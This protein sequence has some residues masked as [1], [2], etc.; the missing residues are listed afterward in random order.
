V[1]I[2][3][4]GT[5][6]VCTRP[7]DSRRFNLKFMY[8]RLFEKPLDALTEED[9][10][11]LVER[12][13]EEGPHLDFKLKLPGNKEE[14]KEL[15]RDVAAFANAY[16][17]YLIFGV[18]EEGG[19]AREL[20]GLEGNPDQNASGVE[21]T[22]RDRTEPPVEVH[23]VAV[24]LENG[25]H[26]LVVEVPRS[27]NAPHMADGRFYRRSGRST[28]PMHYLD[29]RRAF[30]EQGD[31][32]RKLR[33][34]FLRRIEDLERGYGPVE[35]EEAPALYLYVASIPAFDAGP[36]R[37]FG[38][39]DRDRV[40]SFTLMTT[41]DGYR[42]EFSADGLLAS[43]GK[44]SCREFALLTPEGELFLGA[45]PLPTCGLAHRSGPPYVLV[46]D[47]QSVMIQTL[48]TNLP[49]LRALGFEAP[50]YVALALVRAQGY[51]LRDEDPHRFSSERILH[52]PF[53]LFDQVLLDEDA[54]VVG[55]RIGRHQTWEV[56]QRIWRERAARLKPILDRLYQ[57]AGAS[58]SPIAHALDG[59]A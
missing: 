33:G 12:G 41:P 9:L 59:Q 29:V 49:D 35:W 46:H 7:H 45:G 18:Q 15:A 28:A 37:I 52:R 27:L 21:N 48:G 57:A 11:G 56:N 53:L 26:V 44:E 54:R 42:P 38:P 8:R 34:Q 19:D 30:A 16:G 32:I 39:E 58:Q 5:F 22:I 17:G 36:V 6:E 2:T 43:R 23:T 20:V 50:Y 14:K 40:G 55:P 51:R 31:A 3:G 1:R 24:P 13:I 47:V 10:R 25:R 4:L